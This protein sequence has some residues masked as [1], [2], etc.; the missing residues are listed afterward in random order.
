[1][2]TKFYDF[3][4]TRELGA[5]MT[6]INGVMDDGKTY[7]MKLDMLNRFIEFG[8]E[9]VWCMNS[10]VN[11]EIE[12]SQFAD[13]FT[14]SPDDV[15]YDERWNDF[16]IAKMPKSD[17]WVGKYNEKEVCKFFSLATVK[18]WGR[19]PAVKNI[20]VDEYNFGDTRVMN[21]QLRGFQTILTRYLKPN[22]KVFLAGNNTTYNNP[23]LNAYGLFRQPKEE[24]FYPNTTY[25]KDGVTY[26]GKSKM[27]IHTFKR[28]ERHYQD[29]YKDVALYHLLRLTDFSK[30]AFDNES[31]FDNGDN[32]F[33]W[34][35]FKPLMDVVEYYDTIEMN[36][37]NRILVDIYRCDIDGKRVWFIKKS[38]N[39]RDIIKNCISADLLRDGIKINRNLAIKLAKKY[40]TNK[41]YYES[42]TVK[43]NLHDILNKEKWWRI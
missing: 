35:D 9:S 25:V 39:T 10:G 33:D 8:E 37:H 30:H 26:K 12:I 17:I 23:I 31:L 42:E 20:Y 6:F 14:K 32:I 41:L 40:R 3:P 43:Q 24:Y 13:A 7:G 16:K 34:I 38:D 11:L 2:E 5:D 4:K 18:K 29:K 21:L 36:K 19:N 1:M 27:L 15:G 22:V 28:D